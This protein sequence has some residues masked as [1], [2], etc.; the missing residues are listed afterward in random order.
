MGLMHMN[1]LG[2]R[3]RFALRPGM[4]LALDQ[5]PMDTWFGILPAQTGRLKFS[6][7]VLEPP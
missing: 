7:H 3:V 6:K 4:L 1:D 2:G 5:S